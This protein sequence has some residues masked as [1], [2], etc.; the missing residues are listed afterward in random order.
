MRRRSNVIVAPLAVCI[1]LAVSSAAAQTPGAR[2]DSVRIARLAD[3][4]RLWGRIKHFHP[5][6]A[7]RAIDWDR[8]L[9]D[10]I[11]R[12][13]AARTPAE[14][15][16]AI[17]RML[18]PLEDPATSVVAASSGA[19]PLPLER[20]IRI[21]DGVLV[22]DFAAIGRA[23]ADG[24]LRFRFLGDSVRVLLPTVR[25]IVLD[26]RGK[27]WDPA[28][29]PYYF[30]EEVT[31]VA[32]S[33]IAEPLATATWRFRLHSGFVPQAGT[34]SGGYYS[35]LLALS[36]TVIEPHAA[37]RALPISVIVDATTPG[38]LE[39]ASGLRSAGLARIV[40]E[41]AD[42]RSLGA[43]AS[44]VV[45]SD[46]VTVSFRTAELVA[47]DGSLGMTVDTVVRRAEQ[48][49]A[50]RAAIALLARRGAAGASTVAVTPMRPLRDSAYASM[51]Y[52]EVAYRLLALFRFWN[53]IAYFH[54]YRELADESWEIML[55]RY[56]P[57]FEASADAAEYQRTIVELVAEIDDSHGFVSGATALAER[58]GRHQP[59]LAFR[60]VRGEWMVTHVLDSSA[61]VRAGDVV[62]A[63]DGEPIERA[64]DRIAPLVAAS[65]PQAK[66]R[67]ISY[68]IGRGQEGTSVTMKLRGLDGAERT[69]RLVRSVHGTDPRWPATSATVRH[70]PVYG[71]LPSGFGYADLERLELGQVDSMFVAVRNTPGLILDMRG[72]PRGTPWRIASH[73]R[74]R[75]SV[76]AI[77]SRPLLEG[78]GGGYMAGLA[79]TYSFRQPHSPPVDTTYGG[80]V[81]V[82]IN[83]HAQ[84]QSEHLCL[85]V[86]SATDVTFIGT[87]TAGANGDVTRI[88]LPGGITA[89]FSGHDVRHAD[90]RRLQRVGIQ[91]DVRVEPTVRGLAEG[92]DEVLEAAVAFLRERTGR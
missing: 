20:A 65:T 64:V 31:A 89:S 77:F 35:G 88:V 67:S 33:I 80:R 3:A 84:S 55:E 21:D 14:Y 4:G 71:V 62:L 39:I 85:A 18:Q 49:V 40:S 70:T 26:L 43:L 52:P 66:T 42:P 60:H 12:I 92:R 79:P 16:S 57:R 1:L 59:P 53:A 63:I 72:Y 27:G 50:V 68:A 34:S 48:E 54:P 87:P 51:T 78:F 23:E 58:R 13:N 90:G 8:A 25:A 37:A 82:L 76:I 17:A 74:R 91:P 11:P 61:D 46:S 10:V 83:E 81:V 36:P 75:D 69:V 9:V 19:S 47:T 44:A 5:Y 6:L 30:D 56:I 28:T 15:A 29:T 32:S 2:A 7:T 38:G 86:E 22:I 41:E 24:R 45:L 73:L